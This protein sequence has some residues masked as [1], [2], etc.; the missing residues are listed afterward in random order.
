MKKTVLLISMLMLAGISA[1]VVAQ[2]Q[3]ASSS[4]QPAPSSM[5]R[6]KEKLNEMNS[7]STAGIEGVVKMCQA[8]VD[9]SVIE[10][11]IVNSRLTSP[12]PR[13]LIYLHD[14]KIPQEIVNALIEH[15]RVVD[16]ETARNTAVTSA[17]ASASVGNVTY[18]NNV[19]SE[20]PGA[21]P[22]AGYDYTSYAVN[23]PLIIPYNPYRSYGG[24]YYSPPFYSWSGYNWPQS[25]WAWDDGRYNRGP[26]IIHSTPRYGLSD[27]GFEHRGNNVITIGSRARGGL[28]R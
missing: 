11:Y 5:E 14:Q 17:T 6:I 4:N 3:S 8:G 10:T 22:Y 27:R 25:S 1:Q 16:D 24:S 2:E 7:R 20:N 19:Y 28:R 12:T 18:N 15:G 21:A 26:L 23:E 13:D 9:N